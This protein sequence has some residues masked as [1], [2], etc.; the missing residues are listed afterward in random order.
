R[1]T[2]ADFDLPGLPQASNT[3][4]RPSTPESS[5][6]LYRQLDEITGQKPPTPDELQRAKESIENAFVFR[7]DSK[8]KA[9]RERINY[10][11]YGYP[12]D[13]LERYLAGVRRVTVEEVAAAA[14]KYIHR[15][16]L[17]VL[18]VGKAT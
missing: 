8:E 6:A 13:F 18:V 10:E 5:E 4:T 7:F 1:H 9:L 17:A 14:Q 2:T 3:T 16:R 11:F 15:D 12:A